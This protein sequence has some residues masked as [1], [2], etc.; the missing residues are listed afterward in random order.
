MPGGTFTF[1]A[2][3]GIRKVK[4]QGVAVSRE[5]YLKY[6]GK[7]IPPRALAAEG[8]RMAELQ[9]KGRKPRAA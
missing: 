9:C 4:T 2:K 7:P 3:E 8:K 5:F 6:R 1:R